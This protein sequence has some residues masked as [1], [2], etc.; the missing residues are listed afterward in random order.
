MLF[1]TL[2][3]GE[4]FP[5]KNKERSVKVSKEHQR[6]FSPRYCGLLL[7]RN[8]D[9][10]EPEYSVCASVFN[11]DTRCINRDLKDLTEEWQDRFPDFI[12]RTRVYLLTRLY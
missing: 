12:F 2:T 3:V 4:G 10:V 5:P 9:E 7:K 6:S 1:G 11:Y 8:F